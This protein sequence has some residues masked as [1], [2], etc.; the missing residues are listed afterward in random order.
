M[1]DRASIKDVAAAA[2]VSV[3][4]VSRVIN[5]VSTVEP[6]L[7]AR[8][9]AAIVVLN[10]VPNTVARSLKTGAGN[11]IGVVVDSIDDVF[12]S[13]L[14]SAVEQRAIAFGLGVVVC[15][16]GFDAKR[17]REQ[18]VRLTSQH[19]RGIIL[20]PVGDDHDFLEAHRSSTPVVTVDRSVPG[21][22]SV[23]VDDYAAARDGVERLI[24]SGH[25]RIGLLGFDPHIQTARR[26]RLAYEDALS[27]RGIALD[28]ALVP[29]VPFESTAARGAVQDV[30][31][32]DD[33]P[34]ALFLSNARHASVVISALHDLGRTEIATL[35][36]GDFALANAVQPSVSCID[37]DPYLM[38]ALAFERLAE[39]FGSPDLPV[40][41]QVI[42]T[43]FI[44]RTSHT[45]RPLVS[46]STSREQ[47]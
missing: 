5:D 2:G 36:F 45:L 25:S 38:G 20:A 26:R 35:S 27:A 42:P 9:E 40:A 15:S 30:L 13:S 43:G 44:A 10:Y 46:M 17:E 32:L 12:F 14:V 47:A 16:T 19:V 3:T 8:V 24:E 28:P 33:P 4:T 6:D 22:D 21:F 41:D 39:R 37:Q 1:S 23:T 34:T 11:T 7:R 31:E 18:V 29:D